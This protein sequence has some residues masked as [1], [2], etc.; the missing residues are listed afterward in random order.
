MRGGFA[1]RPVSNS[2]PVCGRELLG[3]NANPP[4]KPAQCISAWLYTRHRANAIEA[5]S[6]LNY[7]AHRYITE[8]AGM[9]RSIRTCRRR[10][11]PNP[12]INRSTIQRPYPLQILFSAE[13][14][15]RVL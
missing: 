9:S 15:P 6:E 10:E 14:R 2:R 1:F 7:E 3:R 12:L 8:V 11:M 4:K 13:R 5:S